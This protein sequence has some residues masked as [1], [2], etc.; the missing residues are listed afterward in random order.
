LTID[1]EGYDGVITFINKGKYLEII[2][3]THKE[4]INKYNLR[5]KY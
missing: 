3:E 1:Q 2:T 5:I 4:E